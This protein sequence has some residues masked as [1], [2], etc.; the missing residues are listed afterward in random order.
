MIPLVAAGAMASGGQDP[1]VLS[2]SWSTISVTF[3]TT[4][5]N[6]E[7]RTLSWVFG[8]ARL[9]TAAYVGAG[10]SLKYRINS[11]SWTIYSAP[12]SLQSGQTLAWQI[13]FAGNESSTVTVYLDGAAFTNNSFAT[14]STGFP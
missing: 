9:V 10:G 14:L 1:A 3:P 2:A 5:N 7:D 12:F 4:T 8:G 13:I 6:N 11:G